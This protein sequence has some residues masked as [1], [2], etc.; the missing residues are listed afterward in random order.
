MNEQ[1][2]SVGWLFL[3][4]DTGVE[5]SK[6][7]PVKSGEVPDAEDIQLATAPILLKSLLSAW[8]DI[9]DKEISYIRHITEIDKKLHDKDQELEYLAAIIKDIDD[10]C[11]AIS[12][13]NIQTFADT[14]RKTISSAYETWPIIC[15]EREKRLDKPALQEEGK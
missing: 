11:S 15:H 13:I 1:R 6:S 14:I 3:N 5:F 8:V 12:S 9:Q 10:Q 2:E 7:H 4:P